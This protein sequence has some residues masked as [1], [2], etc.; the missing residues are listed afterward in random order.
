MDL[1]ARQRAGEQ[2]PRRQK[3]PRPLLPEILARVVAQQPAG[4]GEDD[5]GG[6]AAPDDPRREAPPALRCGPGVQECGKG[7]QEGTAAVGLA[8]RGSPRPTTG[9]C[10]RHCHYDKSSAAGSKIARFLS[11]LVERHMKKARGGARRADLLRLLK[12]RPVAPASP[13]AP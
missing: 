9:L 3:R 7:G 1:A 12:W 2:E 13:H 4:E 6:G 5:R 11:R 10:D 8:R